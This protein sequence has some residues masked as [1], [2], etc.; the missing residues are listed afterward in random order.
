MVSCARGN[1][2]MSWGSTSCHASRSG[3]QNL[4]NPKSRFIVR[5]PRFGLQ[6]PQKEKTTGRGLGS[7][8]SATHPG[9]RWT[10]PSDSPLNPA[11]PSPPCVSRA[12]G[13]YWTW[14]VSSR[15]RQ[16]IVLVRSTYG[17]Q[18]RK[19]RVTICKPRKEYGTP[20]NGPS[21]KASHHPGS[22]MSE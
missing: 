15:V 7:V 14:F 2:L 3:H 22:W 6:T 13:S 4:C 17:V 9:P 8:E 10:L 20:S 16:G 19:V 5:M 11:Q 18:A 1:H 21:L 12:L